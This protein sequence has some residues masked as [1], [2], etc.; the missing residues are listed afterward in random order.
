MRLDAPLPKNLNHQP[1]G[2]W[3]KVRVFDKPDDEYLYRLSLEVSAACN[4]F[5]D[6]RGMAYGFQS[7]RSQWFNEKQ[8]IEAEQRRASVNQN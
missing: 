5:F 6:K 8:R 4:R 2:K 1:H 7:M 3:S